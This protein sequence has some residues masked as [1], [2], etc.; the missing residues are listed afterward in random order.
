MTVSAVE[1]PAGGRHGALVVFIVITLAVGGLGSLATTP[2]IPTWYA[3][4]H[5]PPFN[6]PNWVFGPVWTTLYIFMAVAAWRV[7]RKIGLWTAEIALFAAQLALNL[8]WSYIFF[9]AH[10]VGPALAELAVL[11]GLVLWT[12]VRFGRVDR[13]AG[14]LFAPYLAWVGFATLLNAAIWWLN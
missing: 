7:W 9:A 8:A 10:A 14:W 6:P 5:K 3:G 13:P 11:D 12:A 1:K 2:E 4:L